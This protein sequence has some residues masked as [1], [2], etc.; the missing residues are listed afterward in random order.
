V[1]RLLPLVNVKGFES[2]VPKKYRA[3]TYDNKQKNK[4]KKKQR[5]KNKNE[6]K[7]SRR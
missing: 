7:R 5:Q 4:G 1:C 6:K 2:K 3:T